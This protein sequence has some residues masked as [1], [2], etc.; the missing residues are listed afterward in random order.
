MLNKSLNKHF[1]CEISNALALRYCRLK[2]A[3]WIKYSNDNN[4]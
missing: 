3:Y 1:E 4:M 2:W